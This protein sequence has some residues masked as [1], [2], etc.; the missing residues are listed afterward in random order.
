[1]FAFV[2]VYLLIYETKGLTLEQVDELYELVD[3]AW[4]SKA[5]RPAVSFRDARESVSQGAGQGG[6]PMRLRQVS[7]A[8]ADRRAS[9]ATM[10][11]AEESN[12]KGGVM[13]Q[14]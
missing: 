12:E 13:H 1:M 8:Q 4:K 10:T 14:A 11:A 5:W 6:P 2:F 7:Q 9:L 3:K